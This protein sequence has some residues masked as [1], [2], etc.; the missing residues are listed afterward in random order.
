[1]Q[2]KK[3]FLLVGAA[4]TDQIVECAKYAKT[5]NVPYLAEGVTEAALSGLSNYYAETMTYKAQGVLLARYIKKVAKKTKWAM[6]RGD[7]ANFEDAHTGF[8]NAA[9][10][11]GLTKVFDTTVSKDADNSQMQTAAKNF[12]DAAKANGGNPGDVAMY[13]LMSP[14]L[15]IAFANFAASQSCYPRYA[16]IGVTLGI[17]VVAN[18][19]C[20]TANDPQTNAYKGG[21][22]F[23]SP[24]AGLDQ[25]DPAFTEYT[26]N[27]NPKP[28]DIAYG[29]W[30]S[31]KL[32]AEELRAA[33]KDLTRSGFVDTLVNVKKFAVDT[34]PPVDFSN[35]H[36]GGT[37]VNVLEADC[38]SRTY[39]T[40][41]RNKQDF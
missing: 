17:N 25:A 21:A 29:I 11:Q 2:D 1:V 31:E 41:F 24:F 19:V 20:G 8:A 34:Y 37:A 3:V 32:F 39:K 16:G 14:K 27:D 28:D 35:S 13:P 18:T 23:F 7:T 36:F 38:A 40:Q 30:S 15:F 9:A 33:G 26:K 6:V 12:C 5:A 22:T 10:A 4:G